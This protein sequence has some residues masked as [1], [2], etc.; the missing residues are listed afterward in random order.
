MRR[1]CARP[2]VA[3]AGELAALLGV[4]SAGRPIAYERMFAHGGDGATSTR[5][6]PRSARRRGDGDEAPPHA[7]ARPRRPCRSGRREARR[8]A[9]RG[10]GQHDDPSPGR[11]PRTLVIAPVPARRPPMYGG[12]LVDDGRRP[13]RRSAAS[14][15]RRARSPSGPGAGRSSDWIRSRLPTQRAAESA[16]AGCPPLGKVQ[17]STRPDDGPGRTKA[18]P[19]S[20][21]RP[22]FPAEVEQRSMA[23]GSVLLVQH[24]ARSGWGR[25]RR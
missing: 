9:A 16:S 8:S 23:P 2:R 5:S 11:P 15:P 22:A 18:R 12:R 10:P 6:S 7:L 25:L 4:D 24:E 17:S 1:T 21:G 13:S 3:V 14:S 19:P 20:S